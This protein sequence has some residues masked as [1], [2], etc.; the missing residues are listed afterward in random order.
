METATM[1][2]LTVTIIGLAV[3]G[4]MIVDRVMMH[5]EIMADKRDVMH[6]AE[7]SELEQMHA[8]R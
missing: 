3:I 7:V 1:L 8:T 2:F 5:R 4:Y 6:A